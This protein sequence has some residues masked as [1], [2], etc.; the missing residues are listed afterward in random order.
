[1]LRSLRNSTLN[2]DNGLFITLIIMILLV[3]IGIFSPILTVI[4]SIL[5][6]IPA[7]AFGIIPLGIG[8]IISAMGFIVIHFMRR[9][10]GN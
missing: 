4:L 1:L 6:F 5:A 9:S 10:V 2:G 8:L 3:T 7:I